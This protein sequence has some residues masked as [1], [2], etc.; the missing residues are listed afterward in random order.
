MAALARFLEEGVRSVIDHCLLLERGDYTP[1]DFPLVNVSQAQLDGWHES[2][3]GL[4]RLYPATGMQ[5]GMFFHNQL[6][7]S[8][9]VTQ[10][11][12]LFEGELST[13]HFRKAW[14]LVS[15]RHDI[16]R[17]AF[18]GEETRLLQLVVDS[19]DV[20]WQEHDWR[21]LSADEQRERFARYRREDK[22][23]GFDF[24]KAP[25]QRIALFRL[26][27]DRW[28][29]LWTHHHM[30]LDGWCVPLVYKEV[31]L[32]Y[33]LLSRGESVQ[34]P[35]APVYENYIQWLQRRDADEARG[36]WRAALDGIEAP[37]PLA[38]DRLPKD[39]NNGVR[40][41]AFT[42]GTAETQRLEAFAR[43]HHTTVNTL[44]QL[45][46]GTLLHRYSG[47]SQVVFGA[48]TSG[49]PAEVRGIEEMIGLFINTVP[50]KITFAANAPVSSLVADVHRAF[51]QSQEHSYLPLHEIQKQS[52]I[53]AGTP[54]FD[55]LLVFENYPIEAAMAVDMQSHDTQSR[56]SN[57]RVI[58]SGSDEQTN[59]KL[60]FIAGLSGQLNVRCVHDAAN[61][62]GQTVDRLL[63]H[64]ETVLRELPSSETVDAIDI[65]TPAEREQFAVWNRPV[66]DYPRELCIHSLFE[67]QA[68]RRP[69]AVAVILGDAQLTYGELDARANA[70]ASTLRMRHVGAETL[71]GLYAE[72]S[73]EM[74]VAMVAILKAGGAYVPLDPSYPAARLQA[75]LVD[76]EA[77]LVLTQSHLAAGLEGLDCE[78]LLL[79]EYDFSNA[80]NAADGAHDADGADAV[81]GA[82]ASASNLAYVMYT[83][84]STGVPK[85]V[86]VEHRS[87]VRLVAGNH[88]VP[89]G[90]ESRV[91]QTGSTSFD[92]A[93]FEIWGPLLNGGTLV[94]YP[95]K[96]LDL[97][98]LNRQLETHCINT[99]WLTAGL[100]EQWSQQ[101]PR[102]EVQYVLAGGDVV[103]PRAV[104]RVYNAFPNTRVINGYGPTENTT[105]TTCYTVPRDADFSRAIPLGATI[106][107]TTLHVLGGTMQ[108]LPVGAI[109]EL[110]AGGDG[111]A[112]G[113]W[114][115]PELTA[116]KFVGTEAG[117]LYRT[118]DLVR[119]LPDGTL[120]FLGRADD[121]VKIRGFRIELG[122]IEAQLLGQAEV[123]EA[124]VIARNAGG[125]KRLVAYVVPTRSG[126]DE[127][128]LIDELQR[129]LKQVLPEYMVPSAF[130]VLAAFPLNSNGK[131]DRNALPEPDWQ[132]TSSYVAPRNETETKLAEI[133]A[134]LLKLDRVGVED[135]F[136]AI[137]GDSI[138]SIQAVSRAHHAGIAITTRQLFESPT[139]AALAV[140]A[141]D[142]VARAMPQEAVSG[143]LA[144]LPIQRQF[145]EEDTH[146]PHHFNQSLLFV[147]PEGFDARFLRDMVRALYERHDALRL[148]F[149]ETAVHR[150]LSEAMLDAAAIV[151]SETEGSVT[152]RCTHYQ[153]AFDLANGPLFRAVWFAEAR[154]LLLVAHH[155]IIDGVSWRILVGDLEQAFAQYQAG[156]PIA[157]AP[158]TSSFQQW[159]AALEAY[160]TSDALAAE[161]HY[162]LGQYDARVD[163]LPVDRVTGERLTYGSSALERLR[164]TAAETQALLQRCGSAY[165]TTIN[166]LL[167]SGVY[168]GMRNWTQSSGLR[169]VLE[170]HGREELFD[171]LDTTQTVGWFTTVFPLT[172]E[173]ATAA[174]SDVIKSVKEQCRALPNHGLGFGV[175]RYLAQDRFVAQADGKRPQ[176]VFNYLGQLDRTVERDTAF[177][178]ASESMG[179]A[180]DLER[181]RPYQLGLNGRVVEGVLEFTLDYSRLQYDGGTMATLAR[182]I[183]AA[184]A[185]RHRPLPRHRAW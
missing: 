137:G 103:N 87:V 130:V 95:E 132:L 77:R 15:N 68:T 172:L 74:I 128:T 58:S 145:L 79:D 166:E 111:V 85:G 126:G 116:E 163:E 169:I 73:L 168:L 184:P 147:T 175:L 8:A 171:D 12:P 167:L 66:S 64:L 151:E 127:V 165:R 153:Q 60:T 124:V 117:H 110:Y 76:S 98:I 34:W 182:S 121:Q 6:D 30:L 28:Q 99:L 100:F 27:D 14:Q 181:L 133:W 159:G 138:L 65:L 5:Q 39:R 108:P 11:F 93:T 81:D 71:V 16:F 101:L 176:L 90:E 91:L 86:M 157:L 47:E 113:Y 51:Q 32:A 84:G 19:V 185:K 29:M 173:S 162:W 97:G 120:E 179:P 94:L 9:Y 88:F 149:G 177:Q 4:T 2:Y 106:N 119:F 118:G 42:L 134:K 178:P 136:F 92:A 36:F 23:A 114:N 143:T 72:R 22:A 53:A 109:G 1:S 59:Y 67:Q 25:L 24:T 33:R 154:R 112:R 55:S 7:R 56:T 150:E 17:T 107:G 54:L 41:R 140:L 61:F 170:G 96:Y 156:D 26:A 21:G 155:I 102:Y 174:V 164:L 144:L 62:S 131:I 46:W 135:N 152:A 180:V 20:P 142:G 52:G 43:T 31:M 104:E 78:A 75:M 183:E 80:G 40:E 82:R 139:I 48:I 44:V 69:D 146:A 35:D 125:D 10:I 148:T 49:R 122:E 57:L 18:V 129:A 160:A 45:A 38:I 89:M 83:S 161:K 70:L 141:S 13:A 3:A 115:R 158:K 63:A 50:V 105:F 37:T 123:R